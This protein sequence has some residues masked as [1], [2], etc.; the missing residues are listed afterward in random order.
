M[1]KCKMIRILDLL[2]SIVLLGLLSPIFI[3]II[4]ILRF[5]GE[6]EIFFFQERIG[7]NQK[8]F[9]LYKFVTMQKNS[10]DIGTGT[11]TVKND[12]R[13][14]PFG[15]FLRDSKINELPQ[16][17]NIFLGHM[18]V[19]G[20]RPQT[21]RCFDA[22][23]KDSQR[24]IGFMKPGLSG[25]GP[26]IFRSE[27]SILDNVDNVSFYDDVI[28]PYKGEVESWYFDKQNIFY[29][30]ILIIIT[31]WIVIFSNSSIVWRIFTDLPTPPD[32]LKEALNYKR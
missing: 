1:K 2:L 18:S 19:I 23:S 16:L 13:I 26:I 30:F 5:T 8:K 20:P 15:R 9:F 4:I 7:K 31:A 22:F 3:P 29:Y 27:E 14:L 21:K 32:S 24:I 28:S 11:V 10:E 17:I 25:I 12:P 6:G